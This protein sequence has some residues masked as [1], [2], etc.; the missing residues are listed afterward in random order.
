[1]LTP[2]RTQSPS[3]RI[4]DYR[5]DMLYSGCHA[6]SQVG[7]AGCAEFGATSIVLSGGYEDD[8]DGGSVVYVDPSFTVLYL[9]LTG[10]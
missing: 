9:V 3:F 2:P 4:L 7:I 1:M 8:V 6:Q 10:S 5:L